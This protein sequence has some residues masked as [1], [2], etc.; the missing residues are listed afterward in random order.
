MAAA[1]LAQLQIQHP[2]KFQ[3]TLEWKKLRV[4]AGQ[5]F[6]GR[7]LTLSDIVLKTEEQLRSTLI[8][9]Y[10]H[11]LAFERA[12]KRG[13]GHGLVWRQA[14]IDLGGEPSIYHQYPCK[15]NQRRQTV[16]YR[17]VSCGVS[18]DRNRRLGKIE[19]YRHANCGGKLQLVQVQRI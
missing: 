19:R 2:L 1:L 10:A 17:C 3:P 6:Y 12:G 18:F 5:A 16:T 8:H 11:L 15:R 7:K 9:E 4:T 14:V 13:K